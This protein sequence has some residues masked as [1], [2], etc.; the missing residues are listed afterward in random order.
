MNLPYNPHIYMCHKC[1]NMEFEA[2]IILPQSL[3]QD[4]HHGILL[5]TWLQ[6]DF[7]EWGS[8]GTMNIVKNMENNVR[9]LAAA[10]RDWR[11]KIQNQRQ[12]SVL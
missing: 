5:L 4:I 2:N 11:I 8:E 7:Y 6:E 9:L 10:A 12:V 3:W 1:Y